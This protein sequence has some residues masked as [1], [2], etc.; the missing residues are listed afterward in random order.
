M[1]ILVVGGSHRGVRKTALVCALI[2]A[3]PEHRRV[4]V[5]ITSDDHGHPTPVWEETEAGQGTDTARYLA[6]GAV[7]AFLIAALDGEIEQRLAELERITGPEHS[8]IYESNRVV[9]FVRPDLFVLVDDQAGEEAAK[10]SFLRIAATAD[11]MVS[12]GVGDSIRNDSEESDSGV[13]R[14]RFQLIAFERISPQMADWLRQRVPG[15]G[16]SRLGNEGERDPA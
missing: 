13:A 12:L 15:P 16:R 4:A 8:V 7:R 14:P 2:A 1:A 3:L 10:P 9:D 11:A 6:A 5:K